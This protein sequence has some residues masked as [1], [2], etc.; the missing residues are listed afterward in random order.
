MNNLPDW[1]TE[2]AYSML[3]SGYLLENEEPLDMYKRLANAYKKIALS[4][5]E[6]NE[7]IN[8]LEIE[9]RSNR[10]YEY[11]K[12]NW[13]CPATPVCSNFGTER[14]YGISCYGGTIEDSITAIG[15]GVHELMMLSKNG[16]A[17]G[18]DFNNIRPRGAAIQNGKNG[19]SE[20]VVPFIKIFDSAI[21]AANQGST[22]RGAASVSLFWNHGDI[23][24]FL[25]IRRPQG[26]VNRQS[27]NLHHNVFLDDEFFEKLDKGDSKVRE[28]WKE[29]LKTRL[30][31]GEPYLSFYNNIQNRRPEWYVKNNHFVKSQNLC[32]EISLFCDEKH[33][34]V[35]CLSSVN[36]ARYDEWKNHSLFIGDCIHFLDSVMEDFIFKSKDVLGLEKARRFAIYSR[37]LG[38]GVLG[39]HTLLQKNNMPFD[40]SWSVMKLQAEIFSKIERETIDASK[41]LAVLFG[42][43]ELLKGYGLRNSHLRTCAPTFSNS[44]IS[45]GVS[46]GI[47]PIVANAQTDK[48][49]KGTFLVKNRQLENV[50]NQK[51]N[52]NIDEVWKS[53]IINEGSVQHL[54]F[55]SSED[56]EIFLTARE[57]N[58]FNI[59]TQAS[60]RQQFLDQG[61]SINLFFPANVDP[62]YF[63]KVHIEASKTLERLYYCRSTSVLKGDVA[64]RYYDENSCK[65]CEG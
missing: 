48:T 2:Q 57:I 5:R 43:P 50:L 16:G 55:M 62:K 56:K 14:G 36:L 10:L 59:I 52:K 58:Q 33:T 38:L 8:V 26:D 3:K 35:C 20:G 45:G 24:E 19:H 54:D 64:S 53:I 65:S 63:H 51:Y 21:L 61:Q 49:A 17:M 25:K 42:E 44:R 47:Q 32:Q 6:N 4:L 41:E 18:I 37:A 11:M 34:F 15:Q 31:T 13:L 23:H 39:W 12:N 9:Q 46:E 22:R 28:I 60:Q 40:T 30:E 27:L 7:N 1:M 29:I